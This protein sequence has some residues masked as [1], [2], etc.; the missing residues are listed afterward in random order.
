MAKGG[1]YAIQEGFKQICGAMQGCAKW[2]FQA[3]P[4]SFDSITYNV[5]GIY[6]F[7]T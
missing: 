2:V 1:S 5:K 4:K 3:S 7:Q 6:K